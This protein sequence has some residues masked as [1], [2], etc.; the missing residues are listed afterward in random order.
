MYKK[1]IL[2]C[3]LIFLL[4]SDAKLTT[5]EVNITVFQ[6]EDYSF[7]EA[8][9]HS[10][11]TT[12]MSTKTRETLSVGSLISTV[13]PEIKTAIT[14]IKHLLHIISLPKE[15]VDEDDRAL[16]SQQILNFKNKLYYLEEYVAELE[17]GRNSIAS[18]V[19]DIH[20]NLLSIVNS[21][22]SDSFF[23]RKYPQIST[24]VLLGISAL[25]VKFYPL[26]KARNENIAEDINLPCN[27]VVSLKDFQ[28]L[29]TYYRFNKI[30]AFYRSFDDDNRSNDQGIMNYIVR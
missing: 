24:P 1:L 12:N 16:M 14:V 19:K 29:Y 10:L 9:V 5:N 11:N 7:E 15:I 6:N 22:Y 30:R 18:I 8:I 13:V 25:F 28:S 4:K 17:K 21:F 26:L 3:G 27:I 2:L 23:F 20:S